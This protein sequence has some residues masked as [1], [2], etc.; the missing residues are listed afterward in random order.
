MTF[1]PHHFAGGAKWPLDPQ[2]HCG[3]VLH[4]PILAPR[5][6]TTVRWCGRCTMPG[7]FRWRRWGPK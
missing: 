5:R 3:R 7:V 1:L 2:R 6:N 4:R